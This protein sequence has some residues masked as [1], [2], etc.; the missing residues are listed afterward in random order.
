MGSELFPLRLVN[1]CGQRFYVRDRSALDKLIKE[2]CDM[3]GK[4]LKHRNM[5][6]LVGL[7]AGGATQSC[8]GWQ[9]VRGVS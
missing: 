5:Y 2:Q 4:P 3:N 6:Q 9:S 7:D 8:G 1:P